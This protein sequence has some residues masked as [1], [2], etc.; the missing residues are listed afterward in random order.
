MIRV[1]NIG[2]KEKLKSKKKRVAEDL[3]IS[4]QAFAQ[5][6]E[7]PLR[8]RLTEINALIDLGYGGCIHIDHNS[9]DQLRTRTSKKLWRIQ[10]R[11]SFITEHSEE[12]LSMYQQYFEPANVVTDISTYK[13]L[14][15]KK[16]DIIC[17]LETKDVHLEALERF[18]PESE[19]ENFWDIL[20]AYDFVNKWIHAFID[21]CQSKEHAQDIWKKWNHMVQDT[22]YEIFRP[23][24]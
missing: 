22:E 3:G 14:G 9:I 7:D 4:R 17:S 11:I 8:F 2:L 21:I 10:Y 5:K 1:D 20:P 15:T 13:M 6:L 23:I 16:W 18:G 19:F 12:A 24:F